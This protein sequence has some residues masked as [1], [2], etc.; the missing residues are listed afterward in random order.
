MGSPPAGCWCSDSEGEGPCVHGY[1]FVSYL[2]TQLKQQGTELRKRIENQD[3]DEGELDLKRFAPDRSKLA[4]REIDRMLASNLVVTDEV[5]A[6]LPELSQIKEQR[7]CWDVIFH[8]DYIHL[9]PV[10]QQRK[11]RGGGFTK[12]RAISLE[13][14]RN[15]SSLP[16][17]PIDQRV[18]QHIEL[19]SDRYY[20]SRSEYT[21]DEFAALVELVGADNVVADGVSIEVKRRPLVLAI[22]QRDAFCDFRIA[23]EQGNCK[24]ELPMVV[25]QE[26]LAALDL[27]NQIVYISQSGEQVIGIVKRLVSMPPIS[28][29]HRAGLI[30]KARELQKVV[31]IRL[32]EADGGPV[33]AE[34]APLA[35]LL[36]SRT[37]GA[38]DL[39]IR[40][41][42]AGG[43]LRRPGIE[44]T[45]RSATRDGKPIQ[46]Q[47]LL[48]DELRRGHAAVRSLGVSV[49][50][51]NWFGSIAD[52]RAGLS[53]LEKLQS[54]DNEIEV[55]W[56]QSSAQPI[57]VLGNLTSKNVRVDISSKRNWFGVT[58]ECNFGGKTMPLKALLDGLATSDNDE[59]SGDYLKVGESQWARVSQQLRER[60]KKLRDATNSDRSSLRLD[61]TAAP[62]I[63]DLMDGDF[64]VNAAK[65][66]QKC[67][68]RL[69]R[70]EKL[71]PELPASL[72]ATLRD[73]QIEG[74]NWLRRLAEWGVG[75]ILADD[76]GLGKTLQTLAVLLDRSADGPSLVIA[77]TSVGFNWVREAERFTP[78]LNVHLYRETER[79]EFLPSVGPGDLVIC[80]YGLAL[81]DQKALADVKWST[82][83]LD[84]AQ[85]IKNSNSKTSKAIATLNADWFVALTGTPVE[86]HLGELWSLFHVVSPGVFGGWEQFRK[87]F[88]APIE[89]QNNEDARLSLANRLKPFVLRRTKK[90]VLT[91]LPPRTEMNLYVELSPAERAEYE[92]VRLAALGEIEQLESLPDIKDQR[93]KILAMLTRLR[94]ISCHVG[95]V[96]KDWTDSSAKLDQLCETLVSLKEEGHRAL[97]FSQFTQHLA[98]I[99]AALDA[100][101][102]SYEYLDGSTPAK[103]RQEAVDRFQ[104]GTA[105]A[106]LISLKAGGT[107]LNLTAADY[108][109]HM[110][111]WWN[112]A[113]EDQATDRA[114]RMG[115]DKPVMVYR[116]VARGT[117]EEE[118]LAL[119]ET[120][121]D[122]V[123]GV[124]EGTESAAKLSN[125]DLIRMLRQ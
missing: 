69:S 98:L 42:D 23:D 73:Y 95:L 16:L 103:L 125:D 21:I 89:K 64:E 75:G 94:Q 108:V 96:N 40:I 2:V 122:L 110:D 99:R 61:A 22:I 6:G 15:N 33:V 106:F 113:V 118:I 81:R 119:H 3:I 62:A 11:K 48:D 65:A 112:P 28:V 30:A 57:S 38:L 116:I 31:T 27:P 29:E 78:S 102:F 26:S 9:R 52:F 1:G 120:K 45:I 60:L 107:G 90:E 124:M 88:A 34:S 50:R 39:A 7:I 14:L 84:E 68:D 87:R 66:W 67:L 54:G 10:L 36:R 79:G 92:N 13:K 104:N 105:D 82:V 53:L 25:N 18:V 8:D 20:Y 121:R 117:I 111:P 114:H 56:D 51:E 123:A 47:R 44:P 76:M 32:D 86:N 85:A 41:R 80:S 63:R 12:G 46:I 43:T 109:I 71:Q 70:A 59:V 77:P 72:D 5:D 101:E 97:I 58:G 17:S 91:E 49:D 93:F 74:Y 55:L 115:Q 37:D 83:V 4:L 100:K 19:D 35:V 24:E